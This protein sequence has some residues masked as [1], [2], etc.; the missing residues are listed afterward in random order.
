VAA[1]DRLKS[2]CPTLSVGILTADIMDLGGELALLERAAVGIAHVDVMDGCYCPMLTVGPSYVKGLR[3]PLLKD[4]HL[5]IREP[6]DSLA[7]Y[8]AAGADIVTVQV[9][10]AVHIHRVLQRLGAMESAREPGTRIVRGLALEPGTPLDWLDA[11]LLEEVD[12]ISV[13]GVDPGWG[14]QKLAPAT[15]SRL[16]RVKHIIAE[17]GR[18]IL[19]CVDGGITKANVAEVA[20]AGPDLIVTGSAVFDGKTA[21]ANAV[22]MLAAVCEAAPFGRG[23]SATVIEGGR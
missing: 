9:E 7:E 19:T 20:A 18:D 10:S 6:L 5:M 13:L 17:S 16:A 22:E 2:L 12:M 15:L 3:T 8:V 14:G 4:V 11:P 23:A 21:E 1:V